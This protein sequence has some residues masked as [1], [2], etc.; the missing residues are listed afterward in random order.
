VITYHQ[1]AE[2][3]PAELT[4]TANG[5]LLDLSSVGWS[6]EVSLV[7]RNQ[8]VLTKTTG[9]TGAAEAPNLTVAWAADELDIP[10]GAYTMQVQARNLS[11]LDYRW[12]LEFRLLGWVSPPAE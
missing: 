9:L 3:G 2:L 1:G 10:S 4:L 12:A 6:F 8:V 11:D 7:R 5:D